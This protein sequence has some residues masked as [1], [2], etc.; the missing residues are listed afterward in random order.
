MFLKR[1]LYFLFG[2]VDYYLKGCIVEQKY[3]INI[4]VLLV[5]QGLADQKHHFEDYT[6][7]ITIHPPNGLK[8]FD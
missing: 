1:I 6:Q 2:A 7:R 5:S 4:T 3:K 8:I